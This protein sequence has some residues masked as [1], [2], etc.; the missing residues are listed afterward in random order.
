MGNL[1]TQVP[2]SKI[3][4]QSKNKIPVIHIRINERVIA[5]L[6]KKKKKKPHKKEPFESPCPVLLLQPNMICGPA[7][8]PPTTEKLLPNADSQGPP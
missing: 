5:L 3:E 6:R 1:K 4:D 7:W 2:F 8:A